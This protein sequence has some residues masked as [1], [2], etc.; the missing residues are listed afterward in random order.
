MTPGELDATYRVQLVASLTSGQAERQ[1][2]ID[3]LQWMDRRKGGRLSARQAARTWIWSDLHLDHAD[4]VWCFGRPLRSVEGMRRAL[5]EAWRQTVDETDVVICLGDVTVGPASPAI[6][7]A[8]A[9]LPGEKIF[10]WARSPDKS[11]LAIRGA[12]R[13]PGPTQTRALSTSH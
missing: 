6:D 8:L 13:T 2:I 11:G 4:A 12:R 1:P 7:E 10:Y 9:A 3:M 5:L